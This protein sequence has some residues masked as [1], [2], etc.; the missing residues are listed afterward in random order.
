M[1]LQT[2]LFSSDDIVDTEQ[3]SHHSFQYMTVL[4]GRVY[5]NREGSVACAWAGMKSRGGSPPVLYFE[6]LTLADL[7]PK[8]IH[9]LHSVPVVRLRVT[10]FLRSTFPP[11]RPKNC[12]LAWFL[13]AIN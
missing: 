13:A 6:P 10:P 11:L 9:A 4:L 3:V 2:R 12:I 8:R 7:L 1:I 5:R